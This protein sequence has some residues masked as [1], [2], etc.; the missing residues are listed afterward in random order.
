MQLNFKNN[1]DW[2]WLMTALTSRLGITG[3]P[4][5][6]DASAAEVRNILEMDIGGKYHVG[7]EADG[8]ALQGPPK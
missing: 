5:M 1:P 2:N 7:P 4:V 6:V 3:V 8:L